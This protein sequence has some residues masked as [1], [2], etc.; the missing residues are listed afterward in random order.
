MLAKIF[1]TFLKI[2]AFT[3]GGAYAMIPLIEREAVDKHH[4]LTREEFADG[5]AAAQTCPGPIAINLSVYI[6]YHIRQKTGLFVAS[7]ATLLPSLITILIIASFFGKIENL[8]AVRR[9][10]H[11][12]KPAVTALIAVPVINM[13]IKGG[14]KYYHLWLSVA[15][16]VL[17][18][19]LHFSPIYLILLTLQWALIEASTRKDLKEKQ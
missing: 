9:V 2:G 4:W 17:V 7:T 19:I 11:A 16:A 13:S 12:L 8:D 5:L 3:I 18:G 15:A 6:G 10:F 1:F 14:L